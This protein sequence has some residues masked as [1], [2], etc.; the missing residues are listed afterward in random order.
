MTPSFFFQ[1][2]L[3]SSSSSDFESNDELMSQTPTFPSPS[4]SWGG[5]YKSSLF[6]ICHSVRNTNPF[7]WLSLL[8]TICDKLNHFNN[9]KKRFAYCTLYTAH[10]NPPPL[11]FTNLIFFLALIWN[12]LIKKSTRR[13]NYKCGAWWI[14]AKLAKFWLFIID[15]KYRH[16]LLDRIEYREYC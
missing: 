2:C 5:R 13:E 11:R 16:T 9:F 6:L 1:W 4:L 8:R 10:C 12:L 7:R 3:P 15:C 14:S